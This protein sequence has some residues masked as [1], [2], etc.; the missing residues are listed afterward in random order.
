[1]GLALIKMLPDNFT[2]FLEGGAAINVF[3]N[4]NNISIGDTGV[5][6]DFASNTKLITSKVTE[7]LNLVGPLW[8]KPMELCL[9]KEAE[10]VIIYRQGEVSNMVLEKWALEVRYSRH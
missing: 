8:V 4:Q 10:V 5:N 9:Q 2:N 3:C 1:M 6:Y 7:T